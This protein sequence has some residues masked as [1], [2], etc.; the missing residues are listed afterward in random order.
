MSVFSF[1][2]PEDHKAIVRDR[3]QRRVNFLQP[4]N[5]LFLQKPTLKVPHGGG[6]KLEANSL[7]VQ[8][9]ADWIRNGAPGPSKKSAKVTGIS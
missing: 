3:Q 7:D 9:L 5:S 4:E 6:K 1:Q 2:P 8:V